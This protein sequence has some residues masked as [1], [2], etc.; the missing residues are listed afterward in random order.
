MSHIDPSKLHVPI[1]RPYQ[2]EKWASGTAALLA[3]V[4]GVSHLSL[5]QEHGEAFEL[6]IF[7][8]LAGL[9]QIGIGLLIPIRGSR[10]L[11]WTGITSSVALIAI[12]IVT[13]FV[14]IPI[15][16]HAEPQTVEPFGVFVKM[17]EAGLLLPLAYLSRA[18][19]NG[20]S[21]IRYGKSYASP[22]RTAGRKEG[23]SHMS[24]FLLAALLGGIVVGVAISQPNITS[25]IGK[26]PPA[27]AQNVRQYTLI[28]EA[29]QM[30][31]AGKTWEAW[32]YNGT[33]PAPTLKAQVG[34][35]LR[36]KV[37]NKHNLIHSLHTHLTNYK[38]E[39][40]GSQ[41]NI[42]ASK[43]A[44]SMIPPNG[45][46]TYEFTLTT[47][48]IFYFHCHSADGGKHIAQHINMGL[49]GAIVVDE[50]DRPPAR[51]FTLFYAEGQPGHPAPYVINNRGIPGGEHTLEG[52]FKDGGLNAVAQ[53]LNETVTTIKVKKGEVVRLHIVNI[54]DL[55]HSHH[56]HGFEHRSIRTLRGD[57]WA[58]NVLPL[59]PG[60][61]DTLEFT[62]TEPG[63]WLIH[64]HV[65]NHADAG[66]IA[67]LIIE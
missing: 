24:Y 52:I 21:G 7:F 8:A 23:R 18:T 63:F 61:A 62:A 3:T 26:P 32:T 58:S 65:V 42:I 35:T 14:G 30:Q 67:L 4:A 37:I 51:E 53:Q 40:D 38:F 54:G 36:I 34:E 39:M 16:H 46:Y 59:M 20:A 43:G 1:P 2:S 60:Q 44:G 13:R 29:K 48:G 56:H 10:R 19:E 47:P 49:Y 41:A 31:L 27:I 33:V 6:A 22:S 5:V 57:V 25:M 9:L 12:Y 50:P 55:F 28:I 17:M 11:Y 15:G 64:C 66:M 45:E